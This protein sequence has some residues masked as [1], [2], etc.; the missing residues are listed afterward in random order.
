MLV[1]AWTLLRISRANI[2]RSGTTRPAIFVLHTPA[3]PDD[4]LH[5]NRQL[6]LRHIHSSSGKGANVPNTKDYPIDLINTQS[7][8][9]QLEWHIHRQNHKEASALMSDFLAA[10]PA[11]DAE[12]L[13]AFRKLKPSLLKYPRGNVLLVIQLG[14]VYASMGYI[15]LVT[16]EILPI[17]KHF[18]SPEQLA[19]FELELAI[20]SSPGTHEPSSGQQIFEGHSSD[21]KLPES[22]TTSITPE[23]VPPLDTEPRAS[24]YPESTQPSDDLSVVFEEEGEEYLAM[25]SPWR[26]SD[27]SSIQSAGVLKKMVSEG[28]YDQAYVLLK[29]INDLAIAVPLSLEYEQPAIAVLKSGKLDLE[30]KLECFSAWFSLVPPQHLVPADIEFEEIRRL[31]FQTHL[32]HA[33]LFIRFS[34]ISAEKGYI[35]LSILLIPHIIRCTSPS[36]GRTFIDEYCKAFER[37]LSKPVNGIQNVAFKVK[38]TRTNIRGQAIRALAYIG[39][40]DEAIALLPD[41]KSPTFKLTTYTYNIILQ[42]LYALP[43]AVRQQNVNLVTQLRGSADSAIRT[44]QTD[45]EDAWEMELVHGEV[46]ILETAKPVEFGEDLV[47]MLRYLKSHVVTDKRSD[48]VHP[49]TIVNFM[50]MYLATGRTRALAMLLE[51]C[52][53]KSFFATGNFIFAE[54]LFYRRLQQP[55]LVIK[56]FVDH[57]WLSGLPREE[58]LSRYFRFRSIVRSYDPS[59]GEEPPLQRFYKFDDSRTLPRGKMWPRRVHCNMVWDALV[60]LTT[61]DRHLELLYNR[62]IDFAEHGFDSPESNAVIEADEVPISGL[63]RTPV[64]AAAFTPFMTRMMFYRGPPFGVRILRDMLRLGVRPTSYH[65]TELSGFYARRGDVFKVFLIL[66]GMER[67]LRRHLPKHSGV[68]EPIHEYCLPPP[69]LVTYISILR[70]FL[71]AK[72]LQGAEAV[73]ERLLSVYN[74]I[75]GSSQ[76]ADLAIQHLEDFKAAGDNWVKFLF[77]FTQLMRLSSQDVLQIYP[78]HRD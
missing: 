28:R 47:A 15:E 44:A 10:V 76:L 71:I 52:L 72:N 31:L 30:E 60:E 61:Q 66:D 37:Y 57:F 16:E 48:T 64:G 35:G 9:R 50:S 24:H 21:Y 69:T 56:T 54:M 12:R 25:Q 45:L 77:Y 51:K 63:W 19:H 67:G 38:R 1:A 39:R 17:V 3:V 22:T 23:E 11:D 32:I 59:S 75:P 41:L 14:T 8:I 18:A 53:R 42:R 55:L 40:L 27:H 73:C 70:G 26:P 36:V 5:H 29:E 46:H 13:S 62:L 58:V 33:A 4:N 78:H 68:S 20:I 65:Y 6:S 43:I 2:S 34:L 49:F 7:T 74:Y